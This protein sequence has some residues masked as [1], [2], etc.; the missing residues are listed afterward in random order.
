VNAKL[1]KEYARSTKAPWRIGSSERKTMSRSLQRADRNTKGKNHD[2]FGVF[3][4]GVS[5]AVKSLGVNKG[6]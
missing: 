2:Q 4:H 1:S 5:S 6:T 3:L